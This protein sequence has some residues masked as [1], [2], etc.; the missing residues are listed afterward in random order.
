MT[1]DL[2]N[3]MRR[4]WELIRRVDFTR[5]S[6]SVAKANCLRTA[7]REAKEEAARA[8]ALSVSSL[9]PTERALITLENKSRLNEADHRRIAELRAEVANEQ[10]DAFEQKRALIASAKG[11][12][13]SVTFAK[14]D[15]AVRVMKV[16]PAK[17]K[18][19]IKGDAAS[20]ADRKATAT[21]QARHPHLLPV[22]DAEARA[23]RSVNLATI[24]RIAVNGTVHTF[25]A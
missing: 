13:C 6:L 1:Y 10:A 11:R 21:R 9:S 20:E 4:A 8:E 24:S 25:A 5:V 2:S 7:W 14:K 23:P 3:I 19:H 15:G 12:I 17:L 22:W 16:Q 18:F